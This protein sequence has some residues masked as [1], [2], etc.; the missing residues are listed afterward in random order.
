MITTL[1]RAARAVMGAQ[2]GEDEKGYPVFP[3]P[4]TAMEIARAVLMAVREPGIEMVMDVQD[5]IDDEHGASLSV[6][7]A[8]QSFITM[9]DAIL[10][11]RDEGQET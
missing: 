9:I 6:F 11:E 8:S 10:N 7:S 2:V 4:N 5:S 1:E 3:G